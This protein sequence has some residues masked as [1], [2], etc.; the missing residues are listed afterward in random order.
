VN[1]I[2]TFGRPAG[3]D[4]YNPDFVKLAEAYGTKGVR[5]AEIS[6]FEKVYRDA[7]NNTGVSLIEIPADFMESY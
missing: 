4:L 6:E 5:I 2:K 1:Q 3:S 7:L